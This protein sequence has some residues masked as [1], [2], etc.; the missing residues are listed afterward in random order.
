MRRSGYS[1]ELV[2]NSRLYPESWIAAIQRLIREGRRDEALQNLELF[3]EKYPNYRLP[4]DLK[5]LPAQQ[6]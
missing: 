4:S 1:A 2:R 6:K 3:Q 5:R